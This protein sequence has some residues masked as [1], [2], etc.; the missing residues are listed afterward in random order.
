MKRRGGKSDPTGRTMGAGAHVRLYRWLLNSEAWR[1]LPCEARALLVELYA[2]HNG[3]NNGSLFL[4]VRE[5]A[6]RL[7]VGKTTAARAFAD[8]L[9]R[10][11]IRPNVQGAFSRKVRHATSWVLTEF[12]Y[13]GQLATKDFAR[14]QSSGK[15]QNTVPPQVQMVPPQVQMTEAAQ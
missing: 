11:F 15:I 10:G 13:G 9:D 7:G 6:R 8:L 5:G 1:S 3:A 2:L 4:S 12:E 14:W